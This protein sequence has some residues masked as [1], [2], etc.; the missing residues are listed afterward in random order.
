LDRKLIITKGIKN[1]FYLIL[2]DNIPVEFKIEDIE[3]SKQTGS[4]YKGKV[5]RYSQAMEAFS[6]ILERIKK[7]S[8]QKKIFVKKFVRI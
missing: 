2:E 8:Y 7:L 3:I 5:L 1:T 6:L 4:I